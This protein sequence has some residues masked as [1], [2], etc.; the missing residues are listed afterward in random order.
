MSSNDGSRQSAG[1]RVDTLPTFVVCPVCEG[2]IEPRTTFLVCSTCGLQWFQQRS[3]VIDLM[4]PEFVRQ[5]HTDWCRRQDE[6]MAWYRA[7]L[8]TPME[9]RG[10]LVSEYRALAPLL[11]LTSGRVLDLGGG[12][13]LAREFLPAGIRYV[14]VDPCTEWLDADRSALIEPF[15]CVATAPT[16]IKGVGE[17][18]PLAAGAFDTVLA[19]W[20][21]NHVS[22][23]FAVIEEAARV[24]TPAGRLL[25]VLEDMPDDRS[26]DG[27][28]DTPRR[29]AV[30]SDHIVIDEHEL[31]AW[32]APWFEVR[33]RCWVDKYLTLDLVRSHATHHATRRAATSAIDFGDLRRLTPITRG[34]GYSRGRPVDRYFIEGFLER[35]ALAIR[36]RVLEIGDDAYTRRFGGARVS[37]SDVLHLSSASPSATIVADLTSAPHVPANEF[38]CIVCT[39]TLQLIYDVKAAV[40]TLYRILRPNGV[41][42][43]TVPGIS[44][45]DDPSWASAWS[46]SFTPVSAAR[47]FRE[48]F[49]EAV[50]VETYG[51]VLTA[52]AF[53]HGLAT[54]DLERNELDTADPAYPLLIT[55][56]ALKQSTDTASVFSQ[57]AESASPTRERQG[58]VS[59]VI[60]CFN[61]AEFLSQAIESALQ[62][63]YRHLEIVVIDD[64]ST[65]D[66]RD[67][68]LRYSSVRYEYQQNRGLARAR[69]TGIHNTTGEFVVFLDADDRLVPTAVEAGVEQLRAHPQAGYTAGHYRRIDHNGSVI[70]DWPPAPAATDPL[71]ALLKNNHVGMIA[72]V[73]FRR[74]AIETVGGFD[75]QWKACEDY[76]LYLRIARE[77]PTCA[78][79]ELIAEYRKHSRAMS[80]DAER[81]LRAA[82]GVLNAHR[83]RSEDEPDRQ[84]AW[85]E[86]LA[87]WRR[88]YGQL[89][90]EEVRE[91]WGTRGRRLRS[92]R[93]WLTLAWHAPAE[94]IATIRRMKEARIV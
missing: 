58:L 39:Q 90:A 76:D 15:P 82:V 77:F 7:V 22:R 30:Q 18:L 36:G 27:R 71:T 49:G 47:I 60:P 83:P 81:M 37:R 9:A 1:N 25:I 75:P 20:T 86:G 50:Q 34:Y 69:N 72:T 79:Q 2:R 89:L 80:N 48:A 54:E 14:I 17:N 78:H 13:G 32:C 33:Q 92:C 51:N 55:I 74:T 43:V 40:H 56:K 41:A 6:M 59:L 73:M 16:F 42:L 11:A 46:W 38:D 35:N 57:P 61:Q 26:G 4:P 45:I 94:A 52:T 87:H 24:L 88:Y 10:C 65:D 53:L 68:T 62:Q 21:L 3:G 29:P 5:D 28:S 66:T 64:G 23:P 67:V 31:M 84:A 70:D 85:R 12:L 19:L 8:K 93:K 44:Q 91:D 63:T